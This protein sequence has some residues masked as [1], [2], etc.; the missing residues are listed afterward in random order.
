ME[1]I[2]SLRVRLCPVQYKKSTE[3]IGDYCCSISP[4]I[5]LAKASPNRTKNLPLP[6]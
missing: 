1:S 2:P 3:F 6:K 4:T 5:E